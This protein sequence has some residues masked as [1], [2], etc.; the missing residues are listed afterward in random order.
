MC[1][2]TSTA[3]TPLAGRVLRSNA[4]A[5]AAAISPGAPPA[6][7]PGHQTYNDTSDED[8][9]ATHA[10]LMRQAATLDLAYLHVMRAPTPQLDALRWRAVQ[11]ARA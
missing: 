8:S 2:P 3:A 5:M 9:A 7:E 10:E 4:C 1:A 11:P 6:A